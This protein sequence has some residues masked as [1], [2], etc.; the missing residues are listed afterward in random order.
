LVSAVDQHAGKTPIAAAQKTGPS[1]KVGGRLVVEDESVQQEKL[2]DG[3]KLERKSGMLV[4][5]TE[6]QEF[7]PQ[8]GTKGEHSMQHS[9]VSLGESI[10]PERLWREHRHRFDQNVAWLRGEEK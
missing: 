5:L 1:L 2:I 9:D 6:F 4:K 3:G 7:G 8:F 10:V